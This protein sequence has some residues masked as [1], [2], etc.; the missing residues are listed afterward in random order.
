MTERTYLDWNATAPLHP[1]ARA[2]MLEAMDV[3][4]NP[5]SPH[6]E[7]RRAR[8]ILEGARER[9]AQ[10][11]GAK[12]RHV[13]FT[14]GATEAANWVLSPSAASGRLTSP[15]RA[16]LMGA[17]EHPC[18]L[19]GHRFP[20]AAVHTL[21]VD[22]D[23][24]A[25][26]EEAAAR[27]AA[28]TAQHGKGSVM[29]A[30]QAANNETGVLQPVDAIAA[31]IAEHE[32][33]LVCDAVQVPGRASLPSGADILFVS[34]HKVGGP[35]G[36]GAVVVHSEAFA[37]APLINGGGQE[38]RQRSGT[39]NVAAAAGFAA[40]LEAV[41]RDQAATVS[42]AMTL[43][44]QVET[45]LKH[46]HADTVIFAEHSPRLANTT[47]FATPGMTAETS[48]I[49]LDLAGVAVS[50]GSA[51]SSG[52][53]AGSHVLSAMGVPDDLARCALRVSTGPATTARDIEAF[54]GAWETTLARRLKRAA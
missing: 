36:I 4:G 23:G 6:G 28:L 12:A 18:V 11:L 16:L 37:P 14:S 41:I 22:R 40:A 7:G 31:A 42:R 21:P 48:L 30:L 46:L 8:A 3:T 49:A 26:V 35:K 45:G 47:L 50:S 54:L 38:R 13:Y 44:D 43:R 51:C 39:E 2:A 10:A 52:K 19:A 33:V 9:I 32:A 5:S 27:V 29:I 1:A 25:N 24:I 17:T 53:V 20:Q 15:L 34:G